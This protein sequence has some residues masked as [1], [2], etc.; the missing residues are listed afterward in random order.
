MG[1]WSDQWADTDVVDLMSAEL[2]LSW[3]CNYTPPYCAAIPEKKMADKFNRKYLPDID[4]G[5]SAPDAM[6]WVLD[7][8]LLA[9]QSKHL[10]RMARQPICCL[11]ALCAYG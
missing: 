7:V 4:G 2:K 9:D 10:P 8:D 1:E 6:P 5:V 11:E 3:T